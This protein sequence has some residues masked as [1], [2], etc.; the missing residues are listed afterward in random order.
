[1]LCPQTSPACSSPYTLVTKVP[2]PVLQHAVISEWGTQR[3]CLWARPHPGTCACS[4]GVGGGW[5]ERVTASLC[6]CA[7][8]VPQQKPTAPSGPCWML[9]GVSRQ[10]PLGG[11]WRGV[12][13]RTQCL[14]APALVWETFVEPTPPCPHRVC[15]PWASDGP[16]CWQQGEQR[17]P[18]A[19]SPCP[20]PHAALGGGRIAEDSSSVPWGTRSDTDPA[21]GAHELP[22]QDSIGGSWR[23]WR[24][25]LR[26][27]ALASAP[28]LLTPASCPPRPTTSHS[29]PGTTHTVRAM[30]PGRSGG[31]SR[32]GTLTG[33]RHQAGPA[34][35]CS[36]AICHPWGAGTSS[37]PRLVTR[38]ALGSGHS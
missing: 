23:S 1:M 11:L 37:C 34:G 20:H 19:G 4:A 18:E 8:I 21:V 9:V 26:L 31:L 29:P 17:V 24:Q 30:W 32:V 2:G 10:H 27:P 12:P 14:G 33:Y 6:F 15:T 7:W 35:L 13:D 16:F 36:R 22:A 28:P 25:G 38:W 5:G 3:A